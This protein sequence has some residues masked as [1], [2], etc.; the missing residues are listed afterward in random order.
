MNAPEIRLLLPGDLDPLFELLRDQREAEA[1]DP[2]PHGPYHGD[3]PFDEDRRRASGVEAWARPLSEPEWRRTWGAFDRTLCVG[4]VSLTGSG[5]RTGLHRADVGLG[6]RRTHRG[7]GVGRS[8]MTAAIDWARAQPEIDWLDLGVF[9]GNEPAERLYRAL[10]FHDRG[11]TP[12]RF[13]IDGRRI[14]DRSMTLWVGAG[15]SPLAR[16][17]PTS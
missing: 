12:D 8:L 16:T 4:E 14:D 3:E 7:R 2:V 13:R 5:L 11:V 10:G 15:D 1:A 17:K 6:V 9:V